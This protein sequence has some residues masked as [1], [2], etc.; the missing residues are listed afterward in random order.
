M[1]MLIYVFCCEFQNFI[2]SK[3]RR[4]SFQSKYFEHANYFRFEQGTFIVVYI[5]IPAYIKLCLRINKIFIRSGITC[6]LCS[7]VPCVCGC[8]VFYL[9]TFSWIWNHFTIHM[10]HLSAPARPSRPTDWPK[11]NVS[12]IIYFYLY[13][14]HCRKRKASIRNE[15]ENKWVRVAARCESDSK[16]EFV[17][18]IRFFE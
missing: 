5:Q 15:V 16:I 11:L 8:G 13:N 1:R 3:F 17:E 7:T 6:V 4:W 18:S 10:F 9:L 12:T 14:F 2:E